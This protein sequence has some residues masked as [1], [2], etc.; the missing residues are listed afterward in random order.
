M[1]S[2]DW[3]RIEDVF[4]RALA[5]DESTRATWVHATC[6]DDHDLRVRVEELL[7]SHDCE[8]TNLDVPALGP[9]F[10]IGETGL[11]LLTRPDHPDA[12]GPW[13]PIER[14]GRGGM[15]EV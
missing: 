11:E 6:G 7:E 15:G 8:D 12:I 3:D 10:H 9:A 14:L 4:T 13:K 1:R 5:E 2:D